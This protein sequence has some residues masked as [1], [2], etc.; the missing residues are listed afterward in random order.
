[1]GWEKIYM[2]VDPGLL[3]NLKNQSPIAKNYLA[4]RMLL[5]LNFGVRKKNSLI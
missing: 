3:S 1:M 4:V 5:Y 2:V